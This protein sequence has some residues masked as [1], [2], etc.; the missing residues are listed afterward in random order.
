[1]KCLPAGAGTEPYDRHNQSGTEWRV[2]QVQ[3]VHFINESDEIS[4]TSVGIELKEPND[5]AGRH[6][7]PL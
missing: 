1:M 6:Q 7:R 3:V 5:M 2:L 4:T